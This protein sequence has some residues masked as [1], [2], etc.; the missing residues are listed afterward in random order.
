MSRRK[1][2]IIAEIGPNHNGSISIA[3]KLILEA[4]TSIKHER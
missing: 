2:I 3:K 1:T 4:N